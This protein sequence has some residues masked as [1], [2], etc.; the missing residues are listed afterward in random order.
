[1]SPLLDEVLF[2]SQNFDF[3]FRTL[4][5]NEPASEAKKPVLW[6][7]S[8]SVDGSCEGHT[9]LRTHATF[10]VTPDKMATSNGGGMEVDGAGEYFS[11]LS[12]LPAAVLLNMRANSSV[13]FIFLCSVCL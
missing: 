5:L 4:R 1:M 13:W 10:P 9:I 2:R 7:Q 12:R 6:P 3:L 8:L 11:V